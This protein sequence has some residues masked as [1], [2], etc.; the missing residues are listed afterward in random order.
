MKNL[1]LVLFVTQL[2][3]TGCSSISKRDIG[4]G[5]GAVGGGLLANQVGRGNGRVAATIIGTIIG[6]YIGGSIGQSMDDIDKM[7]LSNALETTPTNVTSTWKNPDT[8]SH[9][10]VTPK[11]TYYKNNKPCRT[12]IVNGDINGRSEAIQGNACRNKNGTWIMN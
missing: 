11:K 3:F 1:V 2:I 12:F 10:K 7:K 6:G 9:Y 5:I 8:H 4:T